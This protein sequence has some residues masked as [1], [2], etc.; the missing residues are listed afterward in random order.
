VRGQAGKHRTRSAQAR[1]F[2][3]HLRK[4]ATSTEK[5]LWRILRDRRFSDFKFRRQYPCGSY[6]LDFY[7]TRAKLA[8][9]MDGGGHGCPDQR[10]KD[11]KR[12][13]FLASKGIK[14]LRFWNHQLRDEAEAV[15]FEIWHALM[16]RTGRT[17][18]ITQ[19][20]AKRLPLIPSFSPSGGEGARR[21]D[22]KGFGRSGGNN[23]HSAELPR[24]P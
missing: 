3:R 9:E 7:C 13:N 21:A 4:N 22:E 6:F 11:G 10:A 23:I 1:D 24:T 14:V 18:E 17:Q 2:S 8:V 19:F 20:L 5:S 15:R 16:E 12:K